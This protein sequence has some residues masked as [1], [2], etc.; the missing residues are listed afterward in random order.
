MNPKN[1]A[2]LL[3]WLICQD[4]RNANEG[5]ASHKAAGTKQARAQQD[6]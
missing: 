4:S 2:C 6:Y 3:L 1:A 5:V